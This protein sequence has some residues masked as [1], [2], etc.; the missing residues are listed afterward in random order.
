MPELESITANG[1]DF[2]FQEAGEGPL[3]L[4]LHGFPDSPN[5]MRR[6]L[7]TLAEAGFHA[8]APFMRGYA[9]TGPAPDG[10]YHLGALVADACALHEALGGDDTAV[11][12]GSDWGALTTYG[13]ATFAPER[14]AR[15]VTMA[16]PPTAIIGPRL[17][18]YEQL[19]RFWYQ[20]FFQNPMAEA[21]VQMDDLAFIDG[22]WND[23]S[24]GFSGGEVLTAAKDAIRDPACLTAALS[25]YRAMMDPSFDATG[26]DEEQAAA[27]GT[28]TRPILYL[29]GSTDGCVPGDVVDEARGI[30]PEGS[31]AELIEG[32]G[33]FLHIEKPELV[34][35]LIADFVTGK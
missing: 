15:V 8:V 3:A 2:S 28:P 16:I 1:I 31:R 35:G 20:Q 14:W 30:L 7:P 27:L 23:W 13:A 19:K 24:P 18:D 5:S 4:C 32:A 26:Y 33:H 17:F 10:K 6:L 11:L 25:Y 9:P 34:N 21:V 22:L 12:I 29:H